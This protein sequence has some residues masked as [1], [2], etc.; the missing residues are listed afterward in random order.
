M[1]NLSLIRWSA[2]FGRFEVLESLKICAGIGTGME[3]GV[4]ALVFS[5][6]PTCGKDRDTSSRMDFYIS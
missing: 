3:I 6:V 1:S 5:A 2:L 4:L